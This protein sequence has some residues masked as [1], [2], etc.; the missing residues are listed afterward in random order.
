MRR[1]TLVG[2][3]A[4]IVCCAEAQSQDLAQVERPAPRVGDTWIY[5]ALEPLSKVELRID[6]VTVTDVSDAQL[7]LTGKAGTLTVYD[8]NWALT[9]LRNR[10]YSPPF[11]ILS[12]PMQAGKTWEHSNSYIHER[13]GNTTSELKNEVV[14]WEDVTVPAGS[15]RALRID[16]N[17]FW[18][19]ICGTGLL[20]YKYWYVPKVKALV[21]SETRVYF[22]GGNLIA[23][24]N[25]ELK[26]FRVE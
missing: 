22:A 13:C 6:E 10:K 26:A 7:Q 14:G 5:V 17:G 15:F 25:R 1:K 4:V 16:S 23:G 18:H 12:F 8:K 3:F 19:S 24:E 11:Q 9:Q 21:K 2:L 20:A